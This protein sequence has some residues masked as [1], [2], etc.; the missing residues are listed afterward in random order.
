MLAPSETLDAAFDRL[1]AC[2]CRT[3]PVLQNGSLVGLLT[4]E[5]LAEFLMIQKASG[6]GQ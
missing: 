4:M 5:N 1:Q 2:G 3:L 6:T